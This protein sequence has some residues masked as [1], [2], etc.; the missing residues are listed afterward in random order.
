MAETSQGDA[1]KA[2][3]LAQSLIGILINE[4]SETR[5][6][7]IQAALVMLGDTPTSLSHPTPDFEPSEDDADLA[8]FFNRDE[9]LKPSDYAHLC[10]AYHFATYGS[11]A[12]SLEELK[13]IA[14]D[15]GIILPD[16]LDMTFKQASKKGKKLFQPAG[17]GAYR[18][19]AAGGL[20]FKER[21]RVKPGK[22]TKEGKQSD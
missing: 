13:A 12:F 4:D 8:K 22:K 20:F 18:P 14:I 2:V 16:R 10:A 19:T 9:Q 11:V 17:K 5:R 7:A 3:Q 6:R 21:W 15:A 1:E